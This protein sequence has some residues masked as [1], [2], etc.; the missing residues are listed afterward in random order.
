MSNRTRGFVLGASAILV[1]GIGTA[2]VASYV[3]FDK[4]ALL[5]RQSADELSYLPHD[6]ELVAFANVRQLMGSDLRQRLQAHTGAASAPD[7]LAAH[8]GVNIETDVDSVYVAVLPD[9]SSAVEA[10]APAAMP[11]ILA[12]GRFDRARIEA[13]VLERG[14]V[15]TQHHGTWLLTS[16]APDGG[17]AF[18]E[19]DLVAVGPSKSVRRLLDTRAAGSASVRDNDEVMRLIQRVNQGS[20]W[21]VAR[22][23]SI[24]TN[25]ALP[26]AIT[27]HLPAIT[28]FAASSQIDSQIAATIYAEARDAEAANDLGEVVRGFVALAR[29]QAGQQPA[30]AQLIDSIQLTT[31]G[32]SITVGFSVPA[33]VIESLGAMVPR[34]RVPSSYVPS[35]PAARSRAAVRGASI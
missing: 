29:M 12:R 13:L 2:G 6:V 22:F 5:G 35:Q 33:Q 16:D 27:S 7:D 1:L 20:A 4:L 28:W 25:T 21:T 15:A 19:S 23:D 11:L 34:T 9:D 17:I 31:E 8:T 30:F 10:S 18:L 14:G 26:S 3:G 24:R 32:T